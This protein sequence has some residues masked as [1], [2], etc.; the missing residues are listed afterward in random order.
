MP[1]LLHEP[2]RRGPWRARTR[3]MAIATLLA[4]IGA[5]SGTGAAARRAAPADP[6]TDAA[7]PRISLTFV[8]EAHLRK[9][10]MAAQSALSSR[11][12]TVGTEM[13]PA[14]GAG[15]P[16]DQD[17]CSVVAAYGA[18]E[19]AF[20]TWR[21]SARLR[22]ADADRVELDLSWTRRL[23]DGSAPEDGSD[24]VA[25]RLGQSHLIDVV[26]ARP[27]QPT[28]C[29]HVSLRVSATRYQPV[30]S[31]LLVHRLWLVHEQGGRQWTSGPV[32]AIGTLGEAVAFRFRPIA[33]DLA[34]A[35]GTA[36]PG[37]H[38]EM[39]VRGSVTTD[40]GEDGEFDT[41]I[42]VKREVRFLAMTQLGSGTM[43]VT[44]R[45]GEAGAI[46]LPA[47]VAIARLVVPDLP[48]GPLAPG[49]ARRGQYI[50]LRTGAFFGNGKTS[51]V[52]TVE[53]L[54]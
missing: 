52:L 31:E 10:A 14:L 37:P 11:L 18:P 3:H 49:L 15:T 29:S 17:L 42:A 20:L 46:E 32:E 28:R 25:L 9:G 22:Y 54:R 2:P 41:S 7:A 5:A 48:A 19:P 16:A 34:G 53:R 24:T 39:D 4:A 30:S 44:G 21:V 40:P 45:P 38:I 6:A 26:T 13:T 23:A 8:A 12:A 35:F 27:D 1:S 33:W 36:S 43:H 50:E 47:P 51:L